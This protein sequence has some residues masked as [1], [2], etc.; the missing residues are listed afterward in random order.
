MSRKTA[1]TKQQVE[2]ALGMPVS[3]AIWKYAVDENFVSEATSDVGDH[4]DPV[5]WLAKEIQKLI[6]LGSP[7]GERQ[8]AEG[9]VRGRRRQ[10]RQ[11]GLPLRREVISELLAGIARRKAEVQAFRERYV[12]A[13]LLKHKEVAEWIR[14]RVAETQ[15]PH[16]LLVKLPTGLFPR[17]NQEGRY[18][19]PPG[20]LEGLPIENPA[21]LEMLDYSQPDNQW[22]QRSPAGR[23]GVLRELQL[24]SQELAR[25]FGWQ[26]AQATVFVLTDNVPLVPSFMITVSRGSVVKDFDV[27]RRLRCLARI[28]L[29]IDPAIAPSEVAEHYGK[30][31]A[32]ILARTPRALSEKQM[33][34]AAFCCNLPLL[35]PSNMMEWNSAYPQWEYGRFS[36]FNRDAKRAHARLLD[37]PL[38]NSSGFSF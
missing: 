1:I 10:R 15:Y 11:K 14:S 9:F 35:Q 4:P 37:L 18:H 8:L 13:H 19:L 34:L 3:D 32:E 6:A 28:T 5:A 25:V 2:R 27:P 26:A 16:G 21:P 38:H 20:A 36:N 33:H 17:I 7:A 30:T 23:D 22:V 24:A 31:R 12:P 29:T